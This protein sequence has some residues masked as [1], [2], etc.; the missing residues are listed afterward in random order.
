MRGPGSTRRQA[1]S[2]VPAGTRAASPI[3]RG[4]R[5]QAALREIGADIVGRFHPPGV[6]R[7]RGSPT[8]PLRVPGCSFADSFHRRCLHVWLLGSFAEVSTLARAFASLGLW[9]GG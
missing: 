2:A 3:G 9:S 6:R 8:G 5:W 1:P 7:F 4:W